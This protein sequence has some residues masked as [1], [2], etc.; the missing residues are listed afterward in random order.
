M[1]PQS[2]QIKISKDG[3]R[4]Y[5]IIDSANVSRRRYERVCIDCGKSD[6]L[7]KARSNKCVKCRNKVV[8]IETRNKISKTL[9]DKYKDPNYKKRVI[10]ASRPPKGP[11]HWNW[12]GG[13]TPINQLQR[14]SAEA[15]MWRNTVFNRDEYTCQGCSSRGGKLHAHHIVPWAVSVELRFE[16][17]NGCTLCESCHK[18]IHNYMEVL[19]QTEQLQGK[20]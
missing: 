18:I 6:W 13:L 5:L 8:S 14:N 10:G 12:K 1:R 17:S 16:V 7:I 9:R 2:D 4:Y 20:G 15:T 3:R 11:D 19:Y